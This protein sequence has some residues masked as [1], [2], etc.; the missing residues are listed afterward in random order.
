MV[1]WQEAEDHLD[2]LYK[3]VCIDIE[4]LSILINLRSRAYLSFIGIFLMR[5]MFW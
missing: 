4:I 5:G 2:D 1:L 3:Y